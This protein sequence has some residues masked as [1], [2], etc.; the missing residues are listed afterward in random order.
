MRGPGTTP[1]PTA[2]SLLTA[3]NGNAIASLA[4]ASGAAGMGIFCFP[5]SASSA[6]NATLDTRTGV[7]A[8]TTVT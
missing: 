5:S 1:W 8:G 3:V 2:R 6:S 7:T 4:G